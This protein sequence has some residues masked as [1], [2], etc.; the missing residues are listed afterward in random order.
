MDQSVSSWHL[1]GAISGSL[2][3]YSEP[4]NDVADFYML[5]ID[6][7]S[8]RLDD[9]ADFVS[10]P[11]IGLRNLME[12]LPDTLSQAE[13]YAIVKQVFAHFLF[14]EHYKVRFSCVLK[15]F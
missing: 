3:G 10:E 15:Y 13:V 14:Y 11:L 9:F 6:A 1:R 8:T 4:G 12:Q 2:Y 7:A 5:P